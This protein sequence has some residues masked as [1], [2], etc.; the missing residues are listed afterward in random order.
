MTDNPYL[1]RVYF[2]YTNLESVKTS[3]TGGG[4]HTVLGEPTKTF[5]KTKIS[6]ATMRVLERIGIQAEFSEAWKKMENAERNYLCGDIYNI[7][8]E[9]GVYDG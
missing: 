4:T 3:G 8:K 2:D 7:I 9:V 1:G 6:E 5:S